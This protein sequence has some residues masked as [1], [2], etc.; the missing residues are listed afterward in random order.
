VR[1]T[2][3][4]TSELRAPW[5]FRVA[6]EPVAKFH[7][8]LEGSALLLCDSSTVA[9]APGDLAVLP[10]GTSRTLADDAASRVRPLAQ[11]LAEHGSDA[12]SA[13]GTAGPVR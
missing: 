9:L 12:G 13:F 10:R 7:L 3:F 8:I 5:A 1:S 2:I 4:C 11:L 6:G